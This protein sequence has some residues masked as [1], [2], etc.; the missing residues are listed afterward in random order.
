MPAVEIMT[1][2]L[3]FLKSKC[4]IIHW[5]LIIRAKEKERFTTKAEKGLQ[6]SDFRLQTSD[7]GFQTSDFRLRISDFRLQT[8]DFRLQTFDPS[9]QASSLHPAVLVR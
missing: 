9:Y 5:S 1:V 2:S 8:S 4:L 3:T 7:F 6:T